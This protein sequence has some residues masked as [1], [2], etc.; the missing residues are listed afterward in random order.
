[1]L[2]WR[3]KCRGRRKPQSRH[4]RRRKREK[5]IF[6]HSRCD[7]PPRLLLVVYCFVAKRLWD[8]K[9]TKINFLSFSWKS[10]VD[11]LSTPSRSLLQKITATTNKKRNVNFNLFSFERSGRRLVENF[12]P[13][14]L[15]KFSFDFPLL[16]LWFF[17][18]C[19]KTF[20]AKF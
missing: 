8:E 3:G 2:L 9:E 17:F 16:S 5:P 15:L 4:C 19:W 18:F 6:H 12:M 10:P 20:K 7:F 11:T 1:M 14:H 13:A